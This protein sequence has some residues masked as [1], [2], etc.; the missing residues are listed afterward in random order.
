MNGRQ[1][2]QLHTIDQWFSVDQQ[3]RSILLKALRVKERLWAYRLK[4]EQEKMELKESKWVP[5]SKCQQT[6][7]CWKHPR[8]AGIHPSAISTTPCLLKVYWEA[9]GREAAVMHEA[10]HL[11]LFD[12]G[13]A[14]HDMLQRYGTN[15]AWGDYYKPEIAIE[16]TPAAK[17]LLI[18]GHADA[19]NI[20]VI[21]DIPGAPIFEVGVVHEYKTINDAGFTGLKGKPKPQH[22]AQATIYAGCLNRPVVV[23]LYINKNN[24]NMEDFPIQFDVNVWNQIRSRAETVRNCLVVQQEP[25]PDVGYHCSQCPYVYNCH[26]YKAAKAKKGA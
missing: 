11:L 9:I 5:C 26:A 7:W 25:T 6:G 18:V 12:L 2:V 4:L 15:G 21:D 8:K 19:D 10:K 22:T 3:V 14:V 20:I 13:T 17:E 23:Y 1:V 24:S 16:D